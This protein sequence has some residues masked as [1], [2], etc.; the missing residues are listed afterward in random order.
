MVAHI[1]VER[2]DLTDDMRVVEV[3]PEFGA[4]GKDKVTLRHVLL[5]TA[6]VPGLPP[7]T[8]G[9]D[10][11]DWDHMCAVIADAEP[12][13]E[14]GTQFGYHAKTFG[15]LLEGRSGE[16]YQG[17]AWE[18]KAAFPTIADCYRGG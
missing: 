10:L 6:G 3:W 5:H 13:W 12:W 16:A 8:S 14:P 15:F 11:C 9:A 1:L 2:G 18:P 4:H 17:L 7:D